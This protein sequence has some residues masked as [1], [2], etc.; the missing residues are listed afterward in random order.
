MAL[1][2]IF[3]STLISPVYHE[4]ENF[5]GIE[6][7]NLTDGII[8]TAEKSWSPACKFVNVWIN[9]CRPHST[10]ANGKPGSPTVTLC[11]SSWHTNT[12][13]L[14]SDTAP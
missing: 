13:N 3:K 11:L 5:S 8:K 2:A 4:P 12:A 6:T 9:T 7:M 14:L 1:K 10:A